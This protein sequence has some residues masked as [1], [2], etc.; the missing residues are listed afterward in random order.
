MQEL[1]RD[2]QGL[3]RKE[4]GCLACIY[5]ELFLKSE[6]LSSVA[7]ICM[8]IH[9]GASPSYIVYITFN[10]V[11]IDLGFNVFGVLVGDANRQS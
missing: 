9:A 1:G 2:C 4:R 10:A 5:T 6:Y 8:L 7:L 11:L 3:D